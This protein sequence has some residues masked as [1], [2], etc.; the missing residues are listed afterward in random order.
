M[1]TF[2]HPED[3]FFG[4]FPNQTDIF[5]LWCLI[6][7]FVFWIEQLSNKLSPV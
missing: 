5:L 7:F 4:L 6:Q 3:E 2:T 1:F